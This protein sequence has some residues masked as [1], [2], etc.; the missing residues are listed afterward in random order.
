MGKWKELT[1]K[2]CL[3]H[4]ETSQ[5]KVLTDN[6]NSICDACKHELKYHVHYIDNPDFEI[7]N[8]Y[9]KMDDGYVMWIPKKEVKE[10]AT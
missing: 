7:N 3:F 5:S 6:P 8:Q 10:N 1:L 4:K 2:Q 9:V